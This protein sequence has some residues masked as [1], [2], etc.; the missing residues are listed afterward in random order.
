M[1]L[2]LDAGRRLRWI[3]HCVYWNIVPE[4]VVISWITGGKLNQKFRFSI[5]TSL[6]R[7][8][9]RCNFSCNGYIITGTFHQLLGNIHHWRRYRCRDDRWV[10]GVQHTR[11]PGVLRSF[12][13]NWNPT[14][15]VVREPRLHFLRF[16][17]D[18]TDCNNLRQRNHVVRGCI[19][20]HLLRHL[21]N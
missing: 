17:G 12:H 6:E 4:W 3:F 11:C 19:P 9:G 21:L 10:S 2:L 20:R 15:L 16:F 14:W 7:R 8:R 18:C 13:E 5:R 1:L